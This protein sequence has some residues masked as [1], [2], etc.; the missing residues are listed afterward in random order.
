MVVVCP[1]RLP[2]DACGGIFFRRLG[3]GPDVLPLGTAPPCLMYPLKKLNSPVGGQKLQG[4]RLVPWRLGETDSDVAN[5]YLRS[6]L[7]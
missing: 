4:D 2:P 3:P 5:A 7:P 6:R 1:S